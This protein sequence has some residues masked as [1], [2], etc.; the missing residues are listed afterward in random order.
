MKRVIF[1]V[2]F[3]SDCDQTGDSDHPVQRL[4]IQKPFKAKS[5]N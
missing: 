1:A 3:V 4:K 5:I 2:T